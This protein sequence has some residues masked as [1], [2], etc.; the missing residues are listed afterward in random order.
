M[1]GAPKY[2]LLVRMDVES[3][4]EDEF[5]RWYDEEHIPQMSKVPAVLSARRFVAR[6]GSPKYIAIYEL[7]ETGRM[8][9]SQERAAA[10]ATEW[11]RRILPHT[12]NRSRAFYQLAY[13]EE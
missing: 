11:T 6:Q 4:W 13:E 3:E 10:Q 8:A 2:L 5:N 12:K 7:E 1:P 9:K